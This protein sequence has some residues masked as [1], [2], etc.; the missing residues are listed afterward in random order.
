MPFT[1][2]RPNDV[3]PLSV[4][5]VGLPASSSATNLKT[6]PEPSIWVSKPLEVSNEDVEPKAQAEN[7]PSND[8]LR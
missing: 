3:S 5:I 7:G 1:P 6:A 2:I 8:E 4:S